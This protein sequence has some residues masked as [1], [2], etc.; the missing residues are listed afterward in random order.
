MTIRELLKEGIERLTTAGFAE[1]SSDASLLLEYMCDISRQDILLE[2][3]RDAS[4]D[5]ISTYNE[6]IA[7][8]LQHEPVQYITGYQ[9][10][11]GL[12]FRVSRGT[13]IP[14]QDTETL[15]EEV[16]R[17]N[18]DGNRILDMCTGTGCILLSI[19]KYSNGCVGVGADISEEALITATLNA[20]E[21]GLDAEFIKS[22]LFESISSD[23]KFDI[24]V[25]N[26]PYIKSE[27]IE[28][29][30]PEVRDYEPLSALDGDRDGLLFYRRIID[31]S[32]L[33]LRKEGLLFFEIGY[34]Q[35]A[36]VSSLMYEA[37]YTDVC[38]VKDLAGLDR[39]VY[40]MYLDN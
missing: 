30:M 3:E 7:R 29:L 11:M 13:L 14:R 9:N 34:D 25:S 5:V 40:G 28:M 22:D 38:V 24:I 17:K 6:A 27:E 2:G 20:K 33:Y 36:E 26:P 10:F 39:V 35:G 8:R 23:K 37:G 4:P 15:V 1:A 19:L 31:S 16:L 18:M 32:R 21:L 12:E